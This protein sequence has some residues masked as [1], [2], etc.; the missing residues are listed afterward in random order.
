MMKTYIYHRAVRPELLWD[1]IIAVWPHLTGTLDSEGNYINPGLSI[2][3]QGNA[4]RVRVLDTV[5]KTD[6]DFIVNSHNETA[7]T[8]SDLYNQ[9]YDL[10]LS[11]LQQQAQENNQLAKTVKNLLTVI[12]KLTA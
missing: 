4:V 12:H 2:A 7:P 11:Q 3:L 5:P 1:E 6:L 10:A 9:T 8:S